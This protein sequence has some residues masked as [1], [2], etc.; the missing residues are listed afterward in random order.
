MAFFL[1]IAL[2][3]RLLMRN[4]LFAVNKFLLT[5]NSLFAI[6]DDSLFFANS[7]ISQKRLFLANSLI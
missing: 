1:R 3:M 5:K 4:S 7:L 2:Q 6:S